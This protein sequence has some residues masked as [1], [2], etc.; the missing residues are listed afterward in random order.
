MRTIYL[1]ISYSSTVMHFCMGH[2]TVTFAITPK[3]INT[4]RY[5]GLA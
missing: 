3:I 2:L 1:V 5:W 4:S